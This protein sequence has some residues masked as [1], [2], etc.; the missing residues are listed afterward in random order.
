MRGDA[1]QGSSRLAGD[2]INAEPD[3]IQQWKFAFPRRA[4]GTV[5]INADLRISQRR[6]NASQVR[7]AV[8]QCPQ[9]LN[10]DP[11]DQPEIA[12]VDGHRDFADSADHPVCNF[13][14][15]GDHTAFAA[16]CAH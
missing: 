7:V 1:V 11:V 12:R 9:V 16:M 4:L 10:D 5:I 14:H 2:P 3:P 8:G 15:P 6:D 13:S